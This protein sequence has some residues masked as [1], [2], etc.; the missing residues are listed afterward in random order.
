[1]SIL[2]TKQAAHL[3]LPNVQTQLKMYFFVPPVHPCMDHNYGVISGGHACR[4]CVWPILL[5]AELYT[6]CPR[7]QVLVVIRF[8]VTFLPLKAY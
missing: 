4:D 1:M 3:L 8:N 7:E 2:C 6:T 5:D